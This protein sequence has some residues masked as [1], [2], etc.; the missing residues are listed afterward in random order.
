M[1]TLFTFGCSYTAEYKNNHLVPAYVDYK[2]FKGGKF[3]LTWVE[4]LS[5]KLNIPFI[6]YG[7]GGRGNDLIFQMLCEHINEIKRGDVVIIQ[8]T[9][10]HRYMWVRYQRNEWEHFGA[11]PL[12]GADGIT[13]STHE[14]ICYNRIHPLYVQQI[15]ERMKLIDTLS[16]SIGFD[17]YYW[18]GD[19]KIISPIDS[20][21]R[22]DKKF[23]MTNYIMK[24]SQTPFDKVFELGGETIKKETNGLID[25]LHFGESAH[26]IMGDLF[27]DHIKNYDSKI[28]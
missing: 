6:N 3:P 22:K 13:E 5:N 9:Y 21:N 24:S 20:E 12:N 23:L 17:L 25:D 10:M 14:E 28:I 4:V 11:G 16:K 8:W 19:C 18:S 2:K 26:K 15:Y 7:V 27:Y 1:S